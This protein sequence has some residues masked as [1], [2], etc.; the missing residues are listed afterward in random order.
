MTS[1]DK[2]VENKD[3]RKQ[4]ET[5]I[6]FVGIDLGTSQ[7]AVATS[8]GKL[9]NITSVVGFPKDFVSQK[10]LGK[11]MLIGDDCFNYRMSLNLFYPLDK[12]VIDPHR[13]QKDSVKQKD[14]IIGFIKYLFSLIDKKK[15]QK[16]YA[17]LGAPAR[18][19]A[20]DK[21]AV[22]YAF[23]G[24]VD[25]ILVVS[26]PFLVAYGQGIYGFAVIVDIGAGTINIC[27]MHGSIP[28]EEDQQT[29]YKA[30]NHI[31]KAFY[32]SFKAKVPNA[33]ITIH[34]MREI[35]EQYA[36]VGKKPKKAFV[37][38]LISGKKLQFDVTNELHESCNM[39][40]PDMIKTLKELISQFDLEYQ[41]S[42]RE[43]IILAGCG[44]RI[45]GL[46][47]II[48]QE[49]SELGSIKVNMVDDP[50]FACA[51]GGLKLAQ[52]LP[53]EEWEKIQEKGV[54]E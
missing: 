4:K 13:D 14:A 41:Q 20:D 53:I 24:L 18:A 8:T 2:N 23:D 49:L 48:E 31:D 42:L 6:I 17:V 10:L 44:S 22:T 45:E 39:I 32:D 7:S 34:S 54:F 21:Q 43:N 28:E 29:L 30:G 15:N 46:E 12:G 36:S 5:E 16:I 52:D 33:R 9:M 40:L 19:T 26:E 50:V 51:I 35:K 11:P 25:S 38:S 1:K 47:S 37:E 27:R 3:V